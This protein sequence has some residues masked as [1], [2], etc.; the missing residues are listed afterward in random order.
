MRY[1]QA[2]PQAVT[3]KRSVRASSLVYLNHSQHSILHLSLNKDAALLP[4]VMIRWQLL[5][6]FQQQREGEPF[7]LEPWGFYDEIQV[8][9]GLD[10]WGA[11]G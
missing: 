6:F 3:L 2:R 9:T 10:L 8:L 1:L 11:L 4:G 5:L 7:W